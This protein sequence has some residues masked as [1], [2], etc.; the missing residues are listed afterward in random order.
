MRSWF[1]DA[2]ATVAT[3][4]RIERTDGVAIG[5]VSHD[6][7]LLFD[8]LLHR[9]APGMVPSAIRLTAGLEADSADMA[10]ALSHDSIR[11]EDLASGRFDGA[12]VVAGVV[13]W[14]TLE[15]EAVFAGAIGAVGSDG[16][17]FTAELA[18]MKSVLDREIVPRTSPTCR[19]QFCGPGCGL[20][21][22]RFTHE[23]RLVEVSDERDAVRI[24][25][26]VVPAFL[27]DGSLRWLEGADAGQVQQIES[28]SGDW[29]VL[30]RP[31][32]VELTKGVHAV[33]RQGCDHRLET[34]AARFGNA[35]NFQ[36]EPFLPGNDLLARYPSGRA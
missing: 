34:C 7:N 30:D 28:I 10:G 35:V 18:S 33:V 29:L 17:G 26:G 5:F 27:I 4:W 8:G 21:P 14:E 11:A 24:E 16:A 23:A 13:D 25:T 20:S 32:G 12:R 1:D 2:L 3:Y 6:R 15:F 9:A 19:A 22:V 36:G 31:V